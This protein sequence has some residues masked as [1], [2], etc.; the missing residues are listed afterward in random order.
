MTEDE[1]ILKAVGILQAKVERLTAENAVMSSE[2][3]QLTVD[4]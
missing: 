3:N 4:E 1:L 2:L